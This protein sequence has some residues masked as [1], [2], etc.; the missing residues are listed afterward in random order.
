MVYFNNTPRNK[1]YCTKAYGQETLHQYT[2]NAIFVFAKIYFQFLIKAVK[3][4]R[5]LKEL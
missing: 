4:P 2:I 1:R 3:A 5:Y